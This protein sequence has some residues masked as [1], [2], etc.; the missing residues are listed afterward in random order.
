MYVWSVTRPSA[1]IYMSLVLR[2][3][4]VLMWLWDTV[5][6]SASA[7]GSETVQQSL[8]GSI[9]YNPDCVLVYLSLGAGRAS[10][11]RASG[12]NDVFAE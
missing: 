7:R 4:S 12:H 1:T 3:V 9:H 8:P 10:G 6:I 11:L 5:H 2:E